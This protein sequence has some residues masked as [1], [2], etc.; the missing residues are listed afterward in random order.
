MKKYLPF[1]AMGMMLAM[2]NS[3]IVT[4]VY[5]PPNYGRSYRRALMSPKKISGCR[6]QMRAAKKRK[7]T[8]TK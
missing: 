2:S 8:R 3:S 6:K 7:K 1:L 4:N 5:V